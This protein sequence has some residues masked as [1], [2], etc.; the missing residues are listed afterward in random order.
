MAIKV[1]HYDPDKYP[2]TFSDRE[3]ELSLLREAEAMARVRG[4][5]H[6]I[7]LQGIMVDFERGRRIHLIM[8]LC[9]NQSLRDYLSANG[10]SLRLEANDH[11]KMQ[12]AQQV[13]VIV[14]SI[15]DASNFSTPS[16]IM[17]FRFRMACCT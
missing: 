13:R 3:R 12:W 4:H 8:G 11:K 10:E 5:S 9:T 6:V 7:N 14:A 1:N 15:K 2:I 17:S 16:L